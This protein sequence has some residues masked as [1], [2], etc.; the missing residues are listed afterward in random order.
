MTLTASLS[1][2]DHCQKDQKNQ[3]NMEISRS[4][5]QSSDTTWQDLLSSSLPLTSLEWPRLVP[6][7]KTGER[8]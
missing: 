4:T 6:P 1:S 5:Q 2:E 8:R 3:D 7:T